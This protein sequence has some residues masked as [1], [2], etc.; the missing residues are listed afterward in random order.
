MGLLLTL[1]SF[2]GTSTVLS[3]IGLPLSAWGCYQ[4]LFKERSRIVRIAGGAASVLAMLIV[5][6]LATQRIVEPNTTDFF[7]DGQILSSPDSSPLANESFPILTSDPADGAKIDML[8][9]GAELGVSCW[10]TGRYEGKELT[11]A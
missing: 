11:W 2:L 3:L 7:Y 10:V 9:G 8:A 6:F 1:A 5:A 4:L